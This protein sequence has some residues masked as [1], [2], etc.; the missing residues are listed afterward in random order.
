[1]AGTYEEQTCRHVLQTSAEQLIKDVCKEIQ[2][3]LSKGLICN[4]TKNILFLEDQ[5]NMSVWN[6]GVRRVYV[7]C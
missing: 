7:Y 4:N 1:M 6:Q 5:G 3:G 2:N